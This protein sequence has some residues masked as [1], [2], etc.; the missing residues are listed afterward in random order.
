[1]GWARQISR[2]VTILICF[3]GLPRWAPRRVVR[4]TT[5]HLARPVLG[6]AGMAVIALVVVVFGVT[7]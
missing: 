7:A 5:P 2:I 6:A 1:M 3:R 4:Q